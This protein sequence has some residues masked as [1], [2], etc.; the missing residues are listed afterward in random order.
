[1]TE[2]A[3]WLHRRIAPHGTVLGEFA[4]ELIV[5]F[6][7]V[8]AAFA[9]ENFREAREEASYRAQMVSALRASLDD[10]A[11]HGTE[12]DRQRGSCFATSMRRQVGA[13]VY[14]FRYT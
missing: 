4:F 14:R 3:S 11:G 5:V 1:M 2:R 10:W 7:G 9:L 12:I 8:T 13:S 6:V